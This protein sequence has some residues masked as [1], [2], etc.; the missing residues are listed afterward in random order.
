MHMS[1]ARSQDCHNG[2]SCVDGSAGCETGVQ[3][4]R[5]FNCKMIRFS[6]K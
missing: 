6:F 4:E 5:K 3:S 1:S 2:C